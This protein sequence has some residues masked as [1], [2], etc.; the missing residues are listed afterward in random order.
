MPDPEDPLGGGM[1]EGPI[2]YDV[3]TAVDDARVALAPFLETILPAQEAELLRL[4]RGDRDLGEGDP[5]QSLLDFRQRPNRP[6]GQFKAQISLTSGTT[7]YSSTMG[8]STALKT[9]STTSWKSFPSPSTR[10]VKP[11]SSNTSGP[12]SHA[13]INR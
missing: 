7:L 8:A 13:P 9:S 3:G 1:E 12:F 5:L 2:L 10:P 6:R 4:C 11:P